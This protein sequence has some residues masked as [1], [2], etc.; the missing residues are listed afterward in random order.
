MFLGLLDLIYGFSLAVPPAEAA[1]S[2][3]VRYIAELAPLPA[4]GALWIAIGLVLV[5]GAFMQRDRFAF[6]A[7][8][9]LKVL[10]G[11][12]FLLGWAL[13]GLDRGWVSA[14]IWLPMAVWVYIVSGW[15]EPEAKRGRR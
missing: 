14:A 12:T 3:T 2:P 15:P 1:R 7:A 9:A 11:A 5:A 8:V 4:W 13:V 6:T 10:W